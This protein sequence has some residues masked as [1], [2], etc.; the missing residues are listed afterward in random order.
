MNYDVY[1]DY[2]NQIFNLL[3]VSKLPS[4]NLC[5]SDVILGWKYRLFEFNNLPASN[6]LQTYNMAGLIYIGNMIG[7]SPTNIMNYMKSSRCDTQY[8]IT[9]F[10]LITLTHEIS[11][12]EQ[13]IDVFRY[14]QPGFEAYTD[15]IEYANHFRALKFVLT[16]KD[17]IENNINFGGNRIRINEQQLLSDYNEF[18]FAE[19]DFIHKEKKKM[20]LDKLTLLSLA[21]TPEQVEFIRTSKNYSIKDP[22][23]NTVFIKRNGKYITSYDTLWFVNSILYKIYCLKFRNGMFI[24]I[25][26]TDDSVAFQTNIPATL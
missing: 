6:S 1:T 19:N 4:M 25:N 21:Q 15:Y 2:L 11:H 18:S 16:H 26:L 22:S 8:D 20:M 9:N 17:F 12:A 14:G 3:Y 10:L 24:P 13:D 5:T 23:G 7:M